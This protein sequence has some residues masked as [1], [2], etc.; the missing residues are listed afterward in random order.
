MWFSLLLALTAGV[1][2]AVAADNPF[3][4][5]WKLNP[6][7]SRMAP[8][9]PAL[10]AALV[11]IE[12]FGDSLRFTTEGTGADGKP[13]NFAYEAPLDGKTVGAV[14][15]SPFM[16]STVLKRVDRDTVAAIAMKDG[17][18]VFQDR[19]VVSKNGKTLTISR[20]GNTGAGKP[21]HSTFILERQ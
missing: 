20:T 10:R 8:D 7:K 21:Y 18:E 11:R 12:A 5:T 17:K 4:G 1:T 2:L 3:I 6:A 13:L 15:G 9:A 16:N 14:T 19:R